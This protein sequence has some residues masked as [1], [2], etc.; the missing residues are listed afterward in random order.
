MEFT[1]A[2]A[3]QYSLGGFKVVA[4]YVCLVSAGNSA[5]FGPGD[6]LLIET[7]E[8]GRLRECLCDWWS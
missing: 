8:D 6:S 3:N 1:P 5:G 2:S 4:K 7:G